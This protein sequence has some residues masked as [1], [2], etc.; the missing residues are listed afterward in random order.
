[1]LFK[2][3]QRKNIDILIRVSVLPYEWGS[4]C[5]WEFKVAMRH[6]RPLCKVINMAATGIHLLLFTNMILLVWHD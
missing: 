4:M 1:M 3:N 6:R 2:L 5:H